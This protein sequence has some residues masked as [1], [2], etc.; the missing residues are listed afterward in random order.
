MRDGNRGHWIL[1]LQLYWCSA[2]FEILPLLHEVAGQSVLSIRIRI[3]GMGNF[4]IECHQIIMRKTGLPQMV[5]V[6]AI[7][8]AIMAAV[9]NGW[10]VWKGGGLEF[11]RLRFS[12]PIWQPRDGNCYP[13]GGH[14]EMKLTLTGDIITV[15]HVRYDPTFETRK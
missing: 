5:D 14:I 2:S 13:T 9:P 6:S 12:S 11:D 4:Y 8:Q 1:C 10:G 15:S 3:P 7:D